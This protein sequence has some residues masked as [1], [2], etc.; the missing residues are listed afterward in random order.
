MV[1]N[2]KSLTVKELEEWKK[3]GENYQLIDVR[4]AHE[5]EAGHMGGE[6]IPLGELP[7]NLSKIDKD[8]KI[9]MQCRSGGRSANAAQFLEQKG[10]N[11]VYNLEGGITAHAKEID[12]SVIVI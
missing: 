11:Y 6:H 10:F 5:Y 8:K 1:N 3:N 2:M 9:V 4:E 7:Q 12:P